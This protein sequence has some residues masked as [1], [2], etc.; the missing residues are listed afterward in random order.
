MR[1]AHRVSATSL[2]RSPSCIG[3]IAVPSPLAEF[4]STPDDPTYWMSEF[5][6]ACCFKCYYKDNVVL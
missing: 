3:H 2:S 6:L 4:I 1:V 5:V